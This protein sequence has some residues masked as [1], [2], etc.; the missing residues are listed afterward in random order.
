MIS[1]AQIKWVKSLQVKKY[2]QEEQCF[3]V[4]GRKGVMELL[5]SDFQ[6]ELIAGTEPTLT[7]LA[8]KIKAEVAT[9][10][11]SERELEM[12]GS[13]ESNDFET[14]CRKRPRQYSHFYALL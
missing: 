5:K 1:K 10:V 11:A 6:V 7:K 2:R 12:M 3:V 14:C 13:F 9:E 8:S 4:Q